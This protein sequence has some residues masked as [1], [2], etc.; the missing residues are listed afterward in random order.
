[1]DSASAEISPKAR[2]PKRHGEWV[3]GMELGGGLTWGIYILE[4]GT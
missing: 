3:Y 4:E 1:M 2:S